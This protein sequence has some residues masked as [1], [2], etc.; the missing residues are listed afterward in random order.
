MTSFSSLQTIKGELFRFCFS[1]IARMDSS[2]YYVAVRQDNQLV[3]AFEMKRDRYRNQWVVCQ[4]APEWITQ[5]GAT[6]ATLLEEV[7]TKKSRRKRA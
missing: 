2:K 6:F 1:E 4:P 5:A 7:T 3:T